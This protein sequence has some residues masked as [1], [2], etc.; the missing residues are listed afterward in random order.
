MWSE[1][2]AVVDSK[3]IEAPVAV[4]HEVEQVIESDMVATVATPVKS[5][6]T[7]MI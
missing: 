4:F 3:S 5:T 1:F 6:H 2:T 7:S